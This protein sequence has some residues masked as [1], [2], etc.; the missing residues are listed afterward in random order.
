[1]FNDGILILLLHS[2]EFSQNQ[3]PISHYRMQ[4]WN[5]SEE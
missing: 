1:M 2:S 5:D 4:Y 3:F